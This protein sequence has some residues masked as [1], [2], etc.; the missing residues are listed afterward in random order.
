[1]P[2]TASHDVTP[3]RADWLDRLALPVWMFDAHDALIYLNPATA[4]WLQR[5]PRRLLGQVPG[6]WLDAA[7]ALL[8]SDAATRARG[9]ERRIV[10]P[11]ARLTLAEGVEHFADI[12][13]TA[14]EDAEGLYR[15]VLVEASPVQEF[16]GEDPAQLLPAALHASLRGLAH[17]V[18][19]PLAGLRGAAQL[20]ERRVEDPE[21]RRYL[22]VIRAETDRLHALVE[23]LLTPSPPQALVEVVL[24]EVVERVR[25]LVEAE[26][27]WS[28]RIVRDYDPSV[29][30]VAGDADR[31]IQAVLNLARNALEA[32]ANEVRLRTRVEH[33]VRIGDVAHR[34]AVRL[35]VID[36]GRG[37]AEAVTERVFLPL[38]SGRSD[39]TGLG[40]TL[41]Q[42]IAREHAGSLSFRSRAGHT[43]FTLLL[44]VPAPAT[45]TPEEIDE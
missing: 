8:L 33:G 38:V 26:A 14:V 1:M 35:D 24:H 29:P 36:N 11:R 17:E 43:V 9:E 15:H 19:N 41:A 16:A 40:L 5:S 27:G 21:A 13:L 7:S 42:E 34:Q 3:A 44:P 37:V 20:L 10:L 45:E 22:D 18:R 25:F 12:T 4:Q 31:L 28:V 23:R 39:G 2:A 30:N 32:G 6:R